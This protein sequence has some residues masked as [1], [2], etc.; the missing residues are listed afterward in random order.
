M[1]HLII[2]QTNVDAA[3]VS[4]KLQLRISLFS[5]HI[6]DCSLHIL[7]LVISS[8]STC[9]SH[10]AFVIKHI[11]VDHTNVDRGAGLL[12]VDGIAVIHLFRFLFLAPYA[13]C[14][15]AIDHCIHY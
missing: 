9:A 12:L 10:F 3:G 1:Y 6:P 13:L 2:T 14:H 15:D 11:V 4:G 5:L 8:I 7:A